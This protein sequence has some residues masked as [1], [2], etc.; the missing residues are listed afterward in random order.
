MEANYF[1]RYHLAIE[2]VS[3]LRIGQMTEA[4]GWFGKCEADFLRALDVNSFDSALSLPSGY[5]KL[6]GEWL[7]SFNVV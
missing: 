2:C 5:H 3:W 6:V 1:E 4:C 7:N